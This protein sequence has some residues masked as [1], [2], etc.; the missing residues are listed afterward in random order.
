MLSSTIAQEEQLIIFTQPADELFITE[1]MPKISSFAG[2]ESIQLFKYNAQDGLPKNITSTPAIVYRNVNGSSIYAARYSSITTIK[3]FI[4]SS[5]VSTQ[6][7]ATLD[8]NNI[9]CLDS[10]DKCNFL[11][12]T[13]G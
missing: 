1:M 8:K 4:R 10:N 5:R 12:V 7:E 2:M 9:L 13:K 3:N 11:R 6:T